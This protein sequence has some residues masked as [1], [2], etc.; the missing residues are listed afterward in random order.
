MSEGDSNDLKALW[1]AA[2]PLD[3]AWIEFAVFFDR[4]A[5][6]ALRT[7]PANDSDVLGTDHPRYIELNK[8]WLPSTWEGR[9]KKLAITI[10]GERNH[11]LGEIYSGHLWAIGFLTL[12]NGFDQARTGSAPTISYPGWG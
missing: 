9:L 6:R 4:F 10:E 5:L 7:Y 3:E 11:L 8:G 1:E 12:P 2:V